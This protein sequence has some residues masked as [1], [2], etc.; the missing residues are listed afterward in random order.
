MCERA[1]Q[2]GRCAGSVRAFRPYSTDPTT[3][4]GS[5][6]LKTKLAR[7]IPEKR[8]E[9]R[10]FRKQCGAKVIEE[11]TINMVYTGMREI[12]SLVTETSHLDP[13]KGIT[14]RGYELSEL[15]EIFRSSN[16]DSFTFMPEATFWLLLTGEMPTMDEARWLS[17]QLVK[18]SHLPDHVMEMIQAMPKNLHPMAQFSAAITALHSESIFTKSYHEGVKRSEYWMHIYEDA[19]NLLGKVN[20]IA[21]YIYCN[22]MGLP[23]KSELSPE[24]DWT[25]RFAQRIYEKNNDFINYLRLY[26]FSHADHEGGN[27]SA[28]TCHLVGSAL[29]DPYLSFGA[30]L[31]GL[32]GPLHGLANQETVDYVSR[33]MFKYPNPT[34]EDIESYLGGTIRNG[35]VI[36]GC[37]H[38]VLRVTDPR[39]TL[40]TNFGKK[41]LPHDKRFNISMRIMEIA[42]RVL[43]E[44]G[45][46]SNPWPNV[47]GI[48]GSILW[49]YGFTHTDFYTVLFG[50]SRSLG[51]MASLI[52]D[53]ALLIPLERPK[54]LTTPM[55]KKLVGAS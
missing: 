42:P 45:K 54:S 2:I 27:V 53:R 19:L 41:Y 34:D 35:Q 36:P 1:S 31:N 47:D 38:A 55:F 16:Q 44:V 12:K 37:G 11:I 32:A 46:A 5:D 14:Y 28:H 15:E 40:L 13:N 29:S 3:Q 39:Y 20:T 23:I 4:T 9:I 26:F 48:S 24:D 17:N 25:G 49:H 30:A 51:T 10:T 7:M 33:L 18:R 43:Q 21:A 50:I 6:P 8:E 22:M 52:W